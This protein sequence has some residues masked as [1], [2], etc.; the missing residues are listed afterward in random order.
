MEL[1]LRIAIWESF[2]FNVLVSQDLCDAPNIDLW[3]LI[4]FPQQNRAWMNLLVRN[5]ED[6]C[7]T[8]WIIYFSV[9]Y[10]Q[11]FE[12]CYSVPPQPAYRYAK[13]A[14]KSKSSYLWIGIHWRVLGAQN[15]Y[16]VFVSA[17]SATVR[18]AVEDAI[19]TVNIW[20]SRGMYFI[21]HWVR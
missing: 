14:F 19:L 17:R 15:G 5:L 3:W 16:G 2:C 8:T 10:T 12:H 6:C 13:L 9:N 7:C 18:T 11:L 1:L 4:F 20:K 21:G